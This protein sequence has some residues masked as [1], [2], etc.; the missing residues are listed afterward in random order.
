MSFNENARLDPSQVEDRRGVG[1]G[2]LGGIGGGAGILLLL[3]SMLLG[4]T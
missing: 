3:L 2:T 1:M 4:V